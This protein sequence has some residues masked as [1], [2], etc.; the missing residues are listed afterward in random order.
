MKKTYFFNI[1]AFFFVGITL[2]ESCKKSTF[3]SQYYNPDNSVT[4]NIPALYA[5]L[6]NNAYVIPRYWNLYTLLIPVDGEYSQSAGYTSVNKVYEQPVNYTANKWDNYYTTVMNQ[7]R[8]IQKYYNNLTSPDDKAGYQVFLETANIFFYDQTA[9]MVDLWGDIPYSEAGS[10]NANGSITPAKYDSAQTIYYSII[11]DLDRINTYLD[12]VNLTSFYSQQLAGYD[13]VNGGNL[14][15]WRKYANTL[16]LRLAMRIS[17]YDEATAKSIVMNMLGNPTQYPILS[18]ASESIQINL[19]GNMISTSYDMRNGF[20]VNPYGA[21]F[22][23]DST[24]LPANDPRLPFYFLV[25]ANNV[26]HG[27]SNTLNNTVVTQGQQD[28]L[29]SRWDSTTFTENNNFPGLI[30]DAAESNFL[31][32]E[33]NVRWGSIATAQT[34]YNNGIQQSIIYYYT[35]NANSSFS[36]KHPPMPTNAAIS[37]YQTNPLIAFSSSAS[38]NLNK[39][40]TQKYIDFNVM[41]ANQSWAEYR[42]TKYPDFYF[43]V[44]NS[45]VIAPQPPTRFLYPGSEISL[46]ASNYQQVQAKDN[47]TTKIFWDVK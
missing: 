15:T 26:Y 5:G 44:D 47:I 3:D 21:G 9:Q 4:A 34:A 27:I 10:L 39:I 42:R 24:M 7:Y 13:Y 25:N 14:L 17:Y 41:Q 45:S 18:S 33:A 8:E 19:A 37:A 20:G 12:T 11:N 30:I 22:M 35:I 38:D 16:R 2:L 40:A 46:N 36:G 6:F 43:P 31:V 1:I 28:N 29:F 32:A 23:I